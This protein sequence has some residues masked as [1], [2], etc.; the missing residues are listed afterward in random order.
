[1]TE[2]TPSS[3]RTSEFKVGKEMPILQHICHSGGLG[4]FLGVVT[5]LE[6]GKPTTAKCKGCNKDIAIDWQAVNPPP[7]LP[8]IVKES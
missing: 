2:S 3:L 6:K 8:P 5:K 7:P 1:M 4:G